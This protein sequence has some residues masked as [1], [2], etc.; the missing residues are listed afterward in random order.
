MNTGPD[1]L[2]FAD[3]AAQ[4]AGLHDLYAKAVQWIADQRAQSEAQGLWANG[5]P[6]QKG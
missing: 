4:G 1:A 2:P 3:E 6:T 5:A